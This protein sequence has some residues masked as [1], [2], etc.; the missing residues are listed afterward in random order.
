[1]A[2]NPV[3]GHN[4]NPYLDRLNSAVSKGVEEQPGNSM[5]QEKFQRVE[6][7]LQQFEK[8]PFA[9]KVTDAKGNAVTQIPN[10]GSLKKTA[11]GFELCVLTKSFTQGGVGAVFALGT[12]AKDGLH[13]KFN[14]QKGEMRVEEG[15]DFFGTGFG[16]FSAARAQDTESYVL[17]V[18]HQTIRNYEKSPV[19]SGEDI[20]WKT[21][22]KDL[23]KPEGF[24]GRL[25]S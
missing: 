9:V 6:G 4:P 14:A 18:N 3:G 5:F 22:E 15:H 21:F 2:M 24:W 17:D 11:D 25:F 19:P 10:L 12:L 20:E 8:H 23:S 1:M 13:A 7:Y 16:A